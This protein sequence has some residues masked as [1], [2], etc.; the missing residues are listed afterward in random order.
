MEKVVGGLGD[1][2]KS[3]FIKWADE[4]FDLEGLLVIRV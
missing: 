4:I 1:E 2:F 3:I